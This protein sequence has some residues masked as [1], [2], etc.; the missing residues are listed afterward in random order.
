MSVVGWM[1]CITLAA[2][3][4]MSVTIVAIF[5]EMVDDVCKKSQKCKYCSKCKGGDESERDR[6]RID[7]K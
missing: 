5:Y 7:Q 6:D 3:I 2:Y 1:I 4:W